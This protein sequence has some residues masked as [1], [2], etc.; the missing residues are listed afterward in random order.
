MRIK[1]YT[2]I[3]A[4]VSLFAAT[5]A[6]D[7]QGLEDAVRYSQNDYFGT[8]RS[9]ALGNAM[10][11]LGGDL[12]SIG[13]NPAGS[14]VASYGQ[15]TIT[16]GLS[17]SNVRTS[18]PGASSRSSRTKMTLPNMGLTVNYSTGRERGLKGITFGIISNQTAQYNSYA[19]SNFQNSQTSKAAEAAFAAGGYAESVLGDYNAYE[20]SDVPWDVLTAY[21][22]GLF[23]SY[24]AYGNRYVAVTEALSPGGSYHYV[25]GPLSQTS[26]VSREGSK[27]DLIFNFG[28]NMSDNFYFGLNIG[29]PSAKYSY[30]ETFYEAA[31]N[32]EQF[33][34]TVYNEDNIPEDVYFYGASYGY[35]LVTDVDGLYAKF[36]FIVRPLPSLRLGAAIQTPGRLTV[37]EMWQYTAGSSFS[38]GDFSAS[39]P[40]GEYSYGLR[41]PYVIDLGAAVVLGQFGLLSVDYGFSDFGVMRFFDIHPDSF[42]DPFYDLNETNRLFAGVSHNLRAGLEARLTRHFSARAGLSFLRRSERCWTNSQGNM[43]YADQFINDFY[44]YYENHLVE[45]VSRSNVNSD[46]FSYSFGLGYSSDRSFFAD[47][48]VRFTNYPDSWFSP[49]YD[50]DNFDAA[51][52]TVNAASPVLTNYR[53]AVNMALTLGW[54]F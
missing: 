9:M 37:S 35:N 23:G 32:P 43:V 29:M 12:G 52:N 5:S 7:A 33:L 54:R 36:G 6:A 11:A 41:T 27:N 15:L 13:I 8:A 14:A 22:G 4:V 44:D 39:S 49:Y 2:T 16:P 1:G 50:Y 47:F 21:Q 26:I 46:T 17:I 25:P 45:L 3:F 31:V 40:M 10:T 28:F 30:T 48:A 42:E 19:N 20:N 34:M 53:K 24:N 18:A 51:G 38:D